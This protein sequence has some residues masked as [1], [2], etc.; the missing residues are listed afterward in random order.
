MYMRIPKCMID[1]HH[2]ISSGRT[3]IG[4]MRTAGKRGGSSVT[5]A[6]SMASHIYCVYMKIKSKYNKSVM[7][8]FVATPLY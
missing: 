8:E 5:R 1:S 2:E 4:E 7:N 3:T 6:C